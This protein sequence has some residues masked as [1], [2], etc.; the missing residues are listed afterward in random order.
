ML[1]IQEII[2]EEVPDILGVRGLSPA[3]DVDA[4]KRGWKRKKR[5]RTKKENIEAAKTAS[6]RDESDRQMIVYKMAVG[7]GVSCIVDSANLSRSA[8]LLYPPLISPTTV[9]ATIDIS[10]PSTFDERGLF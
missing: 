7:F 2:K 9:N 5:K 8:L 1:I 4:A 3:T 6:V 10:I